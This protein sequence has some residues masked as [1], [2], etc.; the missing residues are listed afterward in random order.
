M[1]TLQEERFAIEYE[2]CQELYY[3]LCEQEIEDVDQYARD[4]QQL[5][6]RYA[7][8]GCRHNAEGCRMRAQWYGS[9]LVQEVEPSTP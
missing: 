4:W 2:R 1:I 3:F 5:A 9:F 7:D 6:D 8:L